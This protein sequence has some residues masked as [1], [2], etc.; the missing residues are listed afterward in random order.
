MKSGQLK[1]ED[2]TETTSGEEEIRGENG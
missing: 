1:I 2:F